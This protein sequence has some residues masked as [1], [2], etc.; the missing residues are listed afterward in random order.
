MKKSNENKDMD[1]LMQKGMEFGVGVAYM[2][3]KAMNGALDKLEKEG[4]I[5]RKDSERLVKET[6]KKYEAQGDRYAKS[7]KSQM[8]GLMKSAPFVTKKE[9]KELNARIDSIS[10][11]LS[12]RKK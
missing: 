12:N 10:K 5:N 6:V 4:K 9:M 2:A 7:V 3:V 1:K 8:D 11:L